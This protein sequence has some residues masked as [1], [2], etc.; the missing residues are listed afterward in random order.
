MTPTTI[1]RS[2]VMGVGFIAARVS[3]NNAQ[4]MKHYTCWSSFKS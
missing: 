2:V 3:L 1:I 4:Q